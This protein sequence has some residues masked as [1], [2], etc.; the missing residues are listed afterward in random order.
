MIYS[1]TPVI[2]SILG[3]VPKLDSSDLHLIH[4][5]SMSRKQVVNSCIQN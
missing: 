2:L 4:D 5:Y 1:Q 3:A